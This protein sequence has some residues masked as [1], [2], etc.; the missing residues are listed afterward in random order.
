MQNSPRQGDHVICSS[1]NAKLTTTQCDEIRPVCLR[2]QRTGLECGDYPDEHDIIFRDETDVVKK[3]AAKTNNKWSQTRAVPIPKVTSCQPS[4]PSLQHL[5]CPIEHQAVT[6][7]FTHHVDNGQ[8]PF[9]QG[10]LLAIKDFWPQAEDPSLIFCAITATA[11]MAFSK[12]VPGRE[13]RERACKSYGVALQKA[14]IAMQDSKEA[15]TNETLFACLI[16]AFYEVSAFKLLPLYR[17][18]W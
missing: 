3:R 4:S 1:A 10:S 17:T 13:L 2:C 9:G 12:I 6:F 11:L 8:R 18:H 5:S 16:L 14:A 7:F 15:A